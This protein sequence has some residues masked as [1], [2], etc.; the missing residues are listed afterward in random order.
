MLLNVLFAL[1]VV[2]GAER[3]WAWRKNKI[4]QNP[5]NLLD[6]AN[7]KLEELRAQIHKI[8]DKADNVDYSDKVF[9][10]IYDQEKMF[11]SLQEKYSRD[12]KTLIEVINDFIRLAD[13]H[14]NNLISPS[15]ENTLRI[16]QI[17]K[18][19]ENLLKQ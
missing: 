8:T 9:G 10:K 6:T 4:Q 11:I 16:E 12:K 15:D 3:L 18:R 14:K 5:T 7:K 1:V 17:V 19:F 2:F 13:L